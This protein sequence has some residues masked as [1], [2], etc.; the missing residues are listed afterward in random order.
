MKAT[1]TKAKGGTY[2]SKVTA[3]IKTALQADDMR[4]FMRVFQSEIE[5][6]PRMSTGYAS[7]YFKSF[8]DCEFGPRK[9]EIWH[10]DSNGEKKALI[11]TIEKEMPDIK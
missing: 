9:I 5:R 8:P 10:L 6:I 7:N 1:Y 11:A 3:A 4:G 2:L